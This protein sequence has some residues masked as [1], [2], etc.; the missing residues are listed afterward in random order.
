MW[1]YRWQASAEKLSC[2]VCP[3]RGTNV[4]IGGG[5]PVT[6]LANELAPN[7]LLMT[8]H[9]GDVFLLDPGLGVGVI[10]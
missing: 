6:G 1:E 2:L 7:W 10:C 3:G 9:N 8:R 4:G 5:S